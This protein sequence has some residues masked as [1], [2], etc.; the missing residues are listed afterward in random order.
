MFTSNQ[1]I[2]TK[3]TKTAF[4]G[5]NLSHVAVYQNHYYYNWYTSPTFE[6]E[7]LAWQSKSFFHIKE[8]FRFKHPS[9]YGT[10]DGRGEVRKV[11]F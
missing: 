9:K 3:T 7:K 5:E 2:T 1:G 6:S 8:T 10:V 4:K 11:S